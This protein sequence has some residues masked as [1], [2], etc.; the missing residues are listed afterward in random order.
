ME[1]RIFEQGK[2]KAVASR[3]DG[4]VEVKLV[5]D[6]R[7]AESGFS[8]SSLSELHQILAVLEAASSFLKEMER[9]RIAD[10]IDASIMQIGP[11]V[12]NTG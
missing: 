3:D 5:N 7:D 9:R 4:T 2:V 8:F 12:P 1:R 10:A 6:N 11:D